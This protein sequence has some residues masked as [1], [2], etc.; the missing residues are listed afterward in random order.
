MF[1]RKRTINGRDYY[2]VIRCYRER[3]WDQAR[4]RYRAGKIQ[5]DVV[6]SLGHHPTLEGAIRRAEERFHAIVAREGNLS[7]AAEAKRLDAEQRAVER[8]R[9]LDD[10]NREMNP[11]TYRRSEALAL[12][13]KR[14]K[15]RV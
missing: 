11:G 9:R 6:A 4:R 1:I 14:M 10:A 7:P 15:A 2:Q 3:V 12:Y 8:L 5:N 13:E